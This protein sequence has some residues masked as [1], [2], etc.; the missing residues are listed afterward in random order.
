VI[1]RPSVATD[2]DS[3]DLRADED[4][5]GGSRVD[6]SLMSWCLAAAICLGLAYAAWSLGPLVDPAPQK[7]ARAETPRSAIELPQVLNRQVELEA[8]IR[9]LSED[10]KRLTQE[11]ERVRSRIDTIEGSVND[12]SAQ[13]TEVT[14]MART[15]VD[16]IA[17]GSVPS[18]TQPQGLPLPQS[19]APPQPPLQPVPFTRFGVDIGGEAT[20]RALRS[21]WSS[22]KSRHAAQLGEL[23]PVV[24]VRDGARGQPEMRLVAGPLPDAAQ[25]A[26]LCAALSAAGTPCVTA[27]YDGQRIAP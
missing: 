24:T 26:R 12:V 23:Q 4:A 17:T 16:P 8:E 9:R 21:R 10:V 25:A 27:I 7:V 20:L 2:D 19:S 11:R 5:E 6:W 18:A 1:D 13:V 14:R 22:L 3:L 15:G